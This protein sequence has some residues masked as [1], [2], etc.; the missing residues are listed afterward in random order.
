MTDRMPI[1]EQALNQKIMALLHARP[2]CADARSIMLEIVTPEAQA[3]EPTPCNWRIGHF[4]P[5]RGDR[6]T[7]KLRLRA[8][9]DELRGQYEM[10]GYS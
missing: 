7:C 9:H 6:Y 8:I 2:A 5:G 3:D 1:T 10:V 4:D